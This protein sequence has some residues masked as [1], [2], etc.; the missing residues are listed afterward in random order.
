MPLLDLF[1]SLLYIF[2]LI[3]WISLVISV[4]IDIFRSDDLSG[5]GKAGWSLFVI[6]LPWLGVLVYLIARGGSMQQ[7]RYDTA[8]AQQ[9]AA[10]G[11]IRSVAGTAPSVADELA[12]LR[13]LR[14]DGVITEAEFEGQKVKLL[15]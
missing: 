15:A 8:I 5:W 9:Q 7:R 11:Y 2:L 14:D 10:N 1:W 13:Q 3:A 4:V 6:V 12:K